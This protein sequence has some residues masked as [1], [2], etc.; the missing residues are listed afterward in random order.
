MI[1]R[2]N[3]ERR[4]QRRGVRALQVRNAIGL[5]LTLIPERGLD[6]SELLDGGMPLTWYGPG[7]AAPSSNLDP[8][9]DA[10]NRTFFGGS[11]RDV[12]DGCVRRWP[13]GGDRRSASGRLGAL[14]CVSARTTPRRLQPTFA[15]G[16]QPPRITR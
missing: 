9:V 14:R 15:A 12:R 11:R 1:V 7:N 16:R 5:G 4:P 6:A 8:S 2:D 13:D 3:E 10:F